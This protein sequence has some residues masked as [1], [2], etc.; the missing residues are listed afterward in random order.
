MSILVR[1]LAWF[2]LAALLAMP[3]PAL[4]NRSAD[5]CIQAMADA[6]RRTGWLPPGLLHAIG[7]IESAHRPSGTKR[8]VPWPWTINS[9][10]GSFYL[11]S[12]REAV[13]KV[14]ELQSRGVTNI[15]VGCMQVNL[16]HHPNA[17]ANLDAAFEPRH[18]VGYAARFLGE[19]KSEGGTLFKAVGHYHSR[20]PTRSQAYAR[21]VFARWGKDTPDGMKTASRHGVGEPDSATIVE[22]T[23]QR[24]ILRAG[25]G[26]AP[27]WNRVYGSERST[28]ALV[29]RSVPRPGVL[30]RGASNRR[31]LAPRGAGQIELR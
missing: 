24:V 5:L 6:E 17:F 14:R 18:N 8:S 10:E 22:P 21:K 7:M 29:D 13:A 16:H 19:L 11:Q 26:G 27:T 12:H 25:P 4:A 15:D 23:R 30:N 3:L 2:A 20:T 9:T 31:L 28:A 1:R